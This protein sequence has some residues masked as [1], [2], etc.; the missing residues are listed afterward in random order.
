MAVHVAAW[1]WL[2]GG[3]TMK[4]SRFWAREIGVA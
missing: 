3:K 2:R 4:N 1:Y